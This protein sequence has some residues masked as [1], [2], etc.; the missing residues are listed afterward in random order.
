MSNGSG[1]CKIVSAHASCLLRR[2]AN[3]ADDLRHWF[4]LRVSRRSAGVVYPKQVSRT[5]LIAK[6]LGG[7]EYRVSLRKGPFLEQEVLLFARYPHFL[8]SPGGL[9]GDAVSF[10][11]IPDFVPVS[12]YSTMP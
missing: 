11:L 12:G 7:E 4:L 9:V 3:I 5:L 2:L 6:R 10:D 1:T 8:F